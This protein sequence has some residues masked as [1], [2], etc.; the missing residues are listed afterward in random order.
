MKKIYQKPANRSINVS[1]NR[2]N[3]TTKSDS[4]KDITDKLDASNAHINHKNIPEYLQNPPITDSA[5]APECKPENVD[6]DPSHYKDTN[7]GDDSYGESQGEYIGCYVEYSDNSERL[8]ETREIDNNDDSAVAGI[9]VPTTANINQPLQQVAKMSVYKNTGANNSIDASDSDVNPT[10]NTDLQNRLDDSNPN[11]DHKNEKGVDN[12]ATPSKRSTNQKRRVETPPKSLNNPSPESIISLLNLFVPYDSISHW[13]EKSSILVALN[14]IGAAEEQ[15][16]YWCNSTRFKD[17]WKTALKDKHSYGYGFLYNLISKRGGT[18]EY[19]NAREN[20]FEYTPQ[21]PT[22][23]KPTPK[24]KNDVDKEKIFKDFLERVNQFDPNDFSQNL[25]DAKYAQY[26][27]IEE[28]EYGVF[29]AV[30]I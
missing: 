2:A 19:N 15:A 23:K 8:A 4:T 22:K 5:P 28:N 21:T 29:V 16:K 18:K 12:T 17:R 26:K 3:Y 20:G 9:P 7:I 13:N 30:E 6:F 1:H 11:V 27:E 14:C 25:N 24:T 10:E